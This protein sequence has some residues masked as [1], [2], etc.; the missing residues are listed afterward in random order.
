MTAVT[1]LGRQN[2]DAQIQKIMFKKYNIKKNS[3]EEQI[4]VKPE[5]RILIYLFYEY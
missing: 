3:A 1:A 5:T 4:E 2:F